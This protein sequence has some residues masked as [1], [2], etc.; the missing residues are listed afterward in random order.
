[1]AVSA[2]PTGSCLLQAEL[3]S[4]ADGL[5]TEALAVQDV[6]SK[7]AGST[8]PICV[9]EDN[10]AVLKVLR[11]GYS[12]KLRGLI[13][14]QKLSI[15]ISHHLR[16]HAEDIWLEYTRSEDQFADILTKATARP[17][18]EALLHKLGLT[19]VPQSMTS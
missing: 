13:R 9:R 10:E 18:F 15:A 4:L 8:I 19:K 17:L 7:V 11:A 16:E 14:T 5:F 6:L 1:M 12:V 3:V 2:V